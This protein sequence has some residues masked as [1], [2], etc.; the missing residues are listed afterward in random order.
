MSSYKKWKNSGKVQPA[1][2]WSLYQLTLQAT[3]QRTSV[4][5]IN[6]P[7]ALCIHK[8]IGEVI[9]VDNQPF[10]L[11]EDI[12]FTCLLHTLEPRY[13]LPTWK[14]FSETVIPSMVATVHDS[15]ST[16]LCDINNFSFTTDIWS[17]NVASD[18]LLSFIT[19]W[20]TND[21]QKMS[22]VLNV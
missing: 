8:K 13:K 20:I 21:F 22:A 7:R 12:G 16:K 17:T 10:S 3:E 18:S 4:W 1:V 11:V 19:H 14:Y 6:D 9:A 15:I 2:R 5:G